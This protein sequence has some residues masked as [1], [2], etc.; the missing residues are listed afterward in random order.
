MDNSIVSYRIATDCVPGHYFICRKTQGENWLN[1][2]AWNSSDKSWNAD[3]ISLKISCGAFCGF[4]DD[5]EPACE[6]EV[7]KILAKFGQELQ[8]YTP[9]KSKE[10][11]VA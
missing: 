6:E 2:D 7:I 10:E 3:E 1:F 5:T 11:E 9:A 4:E 8:P